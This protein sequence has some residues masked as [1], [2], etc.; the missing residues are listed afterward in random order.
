MIKRITGK[1]TRFVE[2][3]FYLNNAVTSILRTVLDALIYCWL[4][5]AP[6]YSLS[7]LEPPKFL[8]NKITFGIY[9]VRF[10]FNH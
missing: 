8:N 5:V 10:S 4:K 1:G 6:R 9:V 7:T 2:D 3:L